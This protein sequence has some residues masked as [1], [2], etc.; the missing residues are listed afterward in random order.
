MVVLSSI[1]TVRGVKEIAVISRLVLVPAVWLVVI[2]V[3]A[4]KV[5]EIMG[6]S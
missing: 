1:E 4:E 6:S 2:L 3:I 5:G